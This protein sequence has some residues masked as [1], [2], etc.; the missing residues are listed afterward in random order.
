MPLSP[1][2]SAL[3]RASAQRFAVDLGD[4]QVD[5][6]GCYLDLLLQWREHARLVSRRQT[7]ADLIR[8]HI[9][10]AFALVAPLAPYRRLAD[11]GSGAGLPGLPLAILRVDARV[12]LIEAN[13]RKAN[14]LREVTRRLRLSQVTIIAERAEAVEIPPPERFEAVVSRAVWRIPE[15][16]GRVRR[17]LAPG[18][19]VIAMKGPAAEKETAV[20]EIEALGYH[21]NAVERYRLDSGEARLLLILQMKAA[22]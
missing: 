1:A 11:V 22:P 9:A 5:S 4:A 18:G 16:L 3:L 10:D 2:E 21:L 12:T 7:R 14:F 19:V 17:L 15:L 6:L 8:K 13:R 20:V